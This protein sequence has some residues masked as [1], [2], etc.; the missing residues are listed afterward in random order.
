M[1]GNSFKYRFKSS[2]L[3]WFILFT[4][5]FLFFSTVN[6]FAATQ[7]SLTWD[8][9]IE[10]DLA[11]YRVFCREQSQSYDYLNPSW[12][13]TDT[14]CTIYNL[15]ETKTYCFVARAFDTQGLESGN[16]IEVCQATANQSPTADAGPDQTVGEGQGVL[17]NGSNSTD[18]DDGIASYHWT[19]TGGSTVTLSDP[20]GIQPTF[21]APDVGPAGAALTFELSVT[22]YSGL[23]SK[24]SCVVNVT[25]ENEPPQADAGSN[26]TVNEDSIVTLDGI[27]SLDID[28]GIA[29]YSWEQISGPAIILSDSASCQTSF[30]APNVE[31]DGVSLTFNLTVTDAGGLFDTDSCVVNITW[32]NQPPTAVVTPDYTETTEG[33]LV[34]LDGSASTDPDDGIGSYLWS[35]VEGD[36]V[37]LT[38]STSSITSF[39]T[40]KSDSFGKNLKF[41]LT[42]KDFGGLKGT[43]DSA[44]YVSQSTS[45]NSPPN[46]TITSPTEGACFDSSAGIIFVGSAS[47]PEDG[48][49][50]DSLVW[51]SDRDGQI[52]TG[53]SFRAVLSNGTHTI[54]ASVSDSGSLTGSGSITITAVSGKDGV[55]LTATAHKIKGDKYADLTWNG[56]TLTNVDVYRDGSLITTTTNDGSYTHGPF[57]KGKP[58]TYQVCEAGTLNCS[59]EITV[60]W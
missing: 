19:Q 8:P 29:S 18:P 21:I 57:S 59:N 56:A 10:S 45:T 48:D 50:A 9:N 41:K 52:G 43:A 30:T 58:A 40:P 49:L 14:Y 37:S 27:N 28:D 34:T 42:V 11:G 35:Q 15:D 4:L 39:T 25:W 17:L 31:S 47:D 22:D 51:T 20:D 46:V 44:V 33:T 16:S 2:S 13:G 3:F 5:N 24:D 38:D 55:E 7:V 12:E 60:S 32:Q 23:Q 6:C 54:T 36:P 1:V 53:G 26:Q